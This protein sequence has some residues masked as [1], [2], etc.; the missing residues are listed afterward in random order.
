MDERIT[1]EELVY[2]IGPKTENFSSQRSLI[3]SADPQDIPSELSEFSFLKRKD[4]RRPIAFLQSENADYFVYKMV[5]G[6]KSSPSREVEVLK[7]LSLHAHRNQ[8]FENKVQFPR[9]EKSFED[10]FLYPMLIGNPISSLLN[11]SLDQALMLEIF[12]Q[13]GEALA[14]VHLIAR[15]PGETDSYDCC[16]PVPDRG[17]FTISEFYEGIG[18]EFPLLVSAF[19]RVKHGIDQLRDKWENQDFIHYDLRAQNIL[20]DTGTKRISLIDWETAG[21]GDGLYDLGTICFELIRASYCSQGKS[22]P[23]WTLMHKKMVESYCLHRGS[24]SFKTFCG[25]IQYAAIAS[26]VRSS[27]KL[28]ITGRLPKVDLLILKHIDKLIDT[29]E[30]FWVMTP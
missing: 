7:E 18:M 13:L 27:E 28:R 16:F 3:P 14:A 11:E 8:Q 20:Y 29:P 17:T 10:G 6:T 23:T 22:L 25:S 5:D 30:R 24:D 26:L 15:N 2:A 9:L 19:C 12:S 4:A 1:F 21:L